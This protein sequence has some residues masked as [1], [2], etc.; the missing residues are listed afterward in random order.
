MAACRAED[1]QVMSYLVK[2]AVTFIILGFVLSQV[3]PIAVNHITIGS[4]ADQAAMEAAKMMQGGRIDRQSV[5]NAVNDFLDTKGA[6][7]AADIR[8]DSTRVVVSIKR[9]RETW[10]FSRITILSSMVESG[11]VGEE[12]YR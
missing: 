3:T 12:T 5:I 1:G 10:L 7:L 11:A 8:I 6:K 9:I 2:M 4:T